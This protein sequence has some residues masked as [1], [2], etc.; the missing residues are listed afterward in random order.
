M[1]RR[2]CKVGRTLVYDGEELLG[3]ARELRRRLHA[4]PELGLQLPRTQGTV[5][6]ALD[7][8]GLEVTT[9]T[10]TSSVVAVL[11][12]ERPGVTTLLRG[13]M[14]GLP[15][16]EETGL[17]F[18]SKVEGAMH[19][20][21]HDAHMAMLVGAARLLARRK[22]EV[23]GRVVFMFQPGEEGHA[24]A[25]VMLEEG[26]LER[27]GPIDRAFALHISPSLRSGWIATRGG[28]LMASVDSFRVTVKGKG[29][30]ASMPYE[31]IDPVTVAC[32]IVTTLQVMVSRRVPTFDPAV[33]TV[34]RISGGTTFNVIPEM[35]V[36]EGTV[37]TVSK[38]TR[39][40]VLE[41]LQRV[42]Q[43]VA[44]AHQCQADVVTTGDGRQHPDL[45]NPY[46]VTVNDVPAARRTLEIARRLVGDDQVVDMPSPV[47]AAEDWSYVLERVPGSLAFL[48]AAPLGEDHPAALHSNKMVIDEAAMAIGIAMHAA[49]VLS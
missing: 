4:Y 30:H 20:C 34:S 35:V 1:C 40:A 15:V 18:A 43:H 46:P 11:E 42:S 49:M 41:S 31:A 2:R 38:G 48:G 6:E 29:G 37:R 14:D 5:L 10:R 16:R 17:A 26:L 8:L 12:G 33:V 22:N 28:A 23:P 44:E 25:R 32:E 36:L 21:G 13:D 7:G 39:A 3:P 47:M 9:G 19:A 45:P 27:H 24:G